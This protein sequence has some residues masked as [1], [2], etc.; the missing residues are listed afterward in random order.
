M[1]WTKI[2]GDHARISLPVPISINASTRNVPGKGRVKTDEYNSWFDEAVLLLR[3]SKA[4][5]KSKHWSYHA[6]LPISYQRDCDN[7]LKPLQDALVKAGV[8]S[9]DRYCESG[10]FERAATGDGMVMLS[11]QGLEKVG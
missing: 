2:R 10:S 1:S 8:T 9:D 3:V 4:K 11:I 7:C 5:I 6:T